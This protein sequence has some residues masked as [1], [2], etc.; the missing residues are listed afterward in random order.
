[1]IERLRLIGHKYGIG[2]DALR[3]LAELYE[4]MI[5]RTPTQPVASSSAAHAVP[6]PLAPVHFKERYEDLGCIGLGGFSEVREVWDRHV[7]R[8]VALKVQLP[9]RSSPDD[10]ARFRQEVQVMARLQHPA[11]VPLYDWGE[12]PDGRI[13][14]TM[15]RVRGDTIGKRIVA[16]HSLEGP[17][18]VQALR[19]L[20]DDFR[21][22]CEPVAHAHALHIIHRDITPQNLMV[23]ELGEVHVMDWGLARDLAHR[24]EAERSSCV[25]TGANAADPSETSVRTRIAG[26]PFYMP[27]EQARGEIAAM[28]SASDVY[29]FGAVLYEILTGSPPY[30]SSRHAHMAPERT[31]ELVL[32]GPPR[33]VE[34][35]ARS[36]VPRELYPLCRKAMERSP[37]DRY[38]DAGVLMEAMRNWLDG[39]DRR[40][41]AR[42]IVADAQ[43]EHRAKIADMREDAASRRARAR[44]IL[45]KLRSFD[46]AQEKAEGWKLEDD[47]AAIE[48]EALREEINWTQ[49]LRSALNEVP[50]LEEAHAALAEHYAESLLRAEAAHDQ[51]AATGFAALLE[52]HAGKLSGSGRARY[53]ALLR[54]DGRLTLVTDPADVHVVIKPYEPVSRYLIANEERAYIVTTPIREFRLPRG[55]YLLSL[56]APG[57]R[58]AAF[59]VAIGRGEH[60]DGVRPGGATPYPI[61]LL[62]EDELG[63]DDVY[64][65]AGW[66][67]AGGDP[68]AGESLSRRRVWV[69][70]FVMRRHPVTNAEYLEFLNALVAEGRADEARRHCP[71]LPRGTTW[72]NDDGVLAYLLDERSG[73]YALKAP[74][75]ERALPVVSVDWYAATA[76]AAHLARRTGLPWR[77]PSEFE[78]EKAARGVDGRFMPWGDHVEPTW[79]CVSGSHSDRKSVMPVHYYPTDVSP[80]GVRGMA[81]NVRDWCVERWLLDGPRVDGGVLQ[82]E[83]AMADDLADRPIRGGAW[84]SAGDLVRL[85]VRYA[86]PPT[87]R[88]GVLGFRLARPITP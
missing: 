82:I 53:E 47:A 11:V 62:R 59:P 10:C 39:A 80:Y 73:Q 49:K 29:A 13:W 15:K 33:P 52:D 51:P 44:E 60:W 64:V 14:F 86:E 12:L 40:S 4:G 2:D 78:W 84:I 58:E 71:R 9:Q 74:E 81:G 66:F 75:T 27:P 41:R 34:E 26:T 1:M 85:S 88:H 32:S 31:V 24:L 7:R 42:R 22:L 56:K 70:G 57:H 18:F 68:H 79:A 45:E 30:T 65:P 19:R 6:A 72:N 87:K 38:P 35:M 43:R 50:D 37:S 17:A 54:G 28:G 67:I 69:D 61:R 25:T 48:Q 77:L 76:Y 5:P 8:R 63:P 36:E 3:D 46:R 20:L 16:L 83:A 55:S 21:R 23:G